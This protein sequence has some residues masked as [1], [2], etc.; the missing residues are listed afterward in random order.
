MVV[1]GLR[2]SSPRSSLVVSTGPAST[3]IR[4]G[5]DPTSE[6]SIASVTA[7]GTITFRCTDLFVAELHEESNVAERQLVEVL[8]T[9]LFAV[10][11]EEVEA[12]V[13]LVAPL[14]PKRMLNAFNENNTPDM[15]A[16]R[17]PPPLTGHDQVSAQILDELGDWLRDPRG[18]GVP[19]GPLTGGDRSAV[20]NKAVGHLFERMEAKI[21]RYDQRAL[22]DYLVAQNEALVY[23]VK[24]NERML[25]SRLACFGVHAETTKELVKHR[26]DSASASRA[27]RFLIEYVA[28]QPPQGGRL[29][30][31]RGY[32]QML[33]LAQEIIERGTASDFLHF[34]LADFEVSILESGRLGV[35]RDEPV[36]AAMKAYAAASGAR[37]I[38]SAAEPLPG[39]TSAPTQDIV[40]ESAEAMRSEYGFTLR[41]LREVCGGLLDMGTADQVTRVARAD[42]LTQI[43]GARNLDPDL[44]TTVLNAITLTPRDKFMSIGPD[45]V[46]WRFNRNMSYVRRPLVQQGGE[47]VFGFR[48]IL[49]T[50][51]YWLS[52]MTS[53]RLQAN[54]GTQSMKAYISQARGRINHKYA[55]DVAERLSGLG[56]TSELSVSKV[57]AVRIA[58]PDGLDLGDID[59]LAWHPITRTILAV[60]AKD[61]EVARTPAE[62]SHEIAKLFLGKQGK[63]IERST[64]DKHAR[65]INWLSANLA[66]VLAHMGANARPVE[67]S[68]IGVIVTSEPLVTPLVA[69]S[70]IPV[71]AF[72][73]V[74]LDTLGLVPTPT[75]GAR[76]RR[77]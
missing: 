3:W 12:M 70:T 5:D 1:G 54:A 44:V 45:A 65:R 64:V 41:D 69:S 56:L 23:F 73:D 18:A 7:A 46:P 49:G 76:R 25:R 68:V 58:D 34:G 48:S 24:Y 52:S 16:E 63:R 36:D 28:A 38:R 67:C 21:A 10:H 14:G 20:L 74:E 17:L 27:N 59:V 13:E 39:D 22:L 53:G 19:V 26:S 2:P 66:D 43:A 11:T 8:L 75:G 40:N 47:L 9:E 15:R 4:L 55:V 62:M 31:T 60:E 61:F 6:R 42:A 72:A 30:A 57:G 51:P 33:G 77:R 29:P 37:A 35:N 50:G 71:I 32:Y